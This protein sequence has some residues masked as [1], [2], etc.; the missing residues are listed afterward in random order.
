MFRELFMYQLYTL[1]RW[2]WDTG[3]YF[4]TF[5]TFF[6]LY[7]YVIHFW[8]VNEVFSLIFKGIFT[9]C[10]CFFFIGTFGPGNGT[11]ESDFLEVTLSLW[12]RML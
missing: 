12:P 11:F 8:T 9:D 7:F 4:L 5:L 6:L 1:S 3:C 2:R 10:V